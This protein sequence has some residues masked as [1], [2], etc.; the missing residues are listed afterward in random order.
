MPAD[1][2]ASYSNGEFLILFC[3]CSRAVRISKHV[4]R[5]IFYNCTCI[6]YVYYTRIFW[7]CAV[8]M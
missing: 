7:P 2:G 6:Y 5:Q 1:F 4:F 3:G 8:A